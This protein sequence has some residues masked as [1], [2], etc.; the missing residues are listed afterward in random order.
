MFTDEHIVYVYLHTSKFDFWYLDFYF[1]LYSMYTSK[2]NKQVLTT[3]GAVNFIYF[4]FFKV[5]LFEC[6]YIL[7]EK[8]MYKH[9]TLIFFIFKKKVQFIS[10]FHLFLH[11]IFLY[12]Y[13]KR[14]M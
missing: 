10:V 4:F 1:T 7:T 3:K 14:V 9:N 12:H 2:Q 6:F 5:Y 8:C 11:C 13:E